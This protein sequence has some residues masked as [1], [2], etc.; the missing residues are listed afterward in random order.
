VAVKTE[1][2]GGMLAAVI[3]E[4]AYSTTLYRMFTAH[5]QRMVLRATSNGAQS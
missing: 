2:S 5:G 1:L 4:A 3:R